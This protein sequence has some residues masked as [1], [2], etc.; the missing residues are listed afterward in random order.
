MF[1]TLIL[2][3]KYKNVG[4]SNTK[5][6]GFFMEGFTFTFWQ[7]SKF[8]LRLKLQFTIISDICGFIRC[9]RLKI[10]G[11]GKLKLMPKSLGWGG[12]SRLFEKNLKGVHHFG[13]FYCIFMSE[14]SENCRGVFFHPSITPHLCASMIFN[15]K[16][17]K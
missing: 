2:Q 11:R 10:Q 6:A 5:T 1:N 7:T 14:F 8:S 4:L 3:S 15:I 13:F 12:E 9:T 16:D 17:P